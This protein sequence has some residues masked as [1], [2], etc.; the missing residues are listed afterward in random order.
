M[1]VLTVDPRHGGDYK[2]KRMKASPWS[3]RYAQRLL[4]DDKIKDNPGHA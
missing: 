4:T 1:M 3:S 2:I